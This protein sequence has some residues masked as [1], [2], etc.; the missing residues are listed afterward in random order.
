MDRYK[1]FVDHYKLYNDYV[2]LYELLHA[3]N[4]K[5]MYFTFV[6]LHRHLILDSQTLS[7]EIFEAKLQFERISLL[8]NYAELVEDYFINSLKSFPLHRTNIREV[9]SLY[10]AIVKEIYIAI[11]DNFVDI[12]SLIDSIKGIEQAIS[13]F[14]YHKS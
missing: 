7:D 10:D 1:R 6:D 12:H 5:V 2:I 13:C 14:V 11:N 4:N 9:A 3:T 8:A